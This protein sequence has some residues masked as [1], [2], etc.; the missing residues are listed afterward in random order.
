MHIP[1]TSHAEYNAQMPSV[2]E[3][4]EIVALNT[5][6]DVSFIE[7]R[8][9]L[10]FQKPQKNMIFLLSCHLLQIFGFQRFDNS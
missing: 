10:I 7:T 6:P 1:Q 3:Y 4:P 8:K 2:G 5:C 9:R